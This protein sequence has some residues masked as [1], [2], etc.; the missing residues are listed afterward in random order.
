MFVFSVFALLPVFCAEGPV[1]DSCLLLLISLNKEMR[2]LVRSSVW[3]HGLVVHRLCL[4]V[5]DGN[6]ARLLGALRSQHVVRT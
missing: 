4:R 1:H 6:L 2:C 5:Y 3:G